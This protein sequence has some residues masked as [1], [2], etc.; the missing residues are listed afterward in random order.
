MKDM[1]GKSILISGGTSGIG[2]ETASELVLSGA[3]VVLMA[4]DH[5]RGAKAIRELLKIGAQAKKEGRVE[6]FGRAMFSAGDVRHKADCESAVA[7]TVKAFGGLDGLVC[8]AGIYREGEL[9]ALREEELDEVFDTNAKGTILL[10]QAALPVLKASKGAIVNVSSDA[11]V[12]GNYFAAAYCASKG[13]V[14]LFTRALALETAKDGVRVN[15]VAPGDIDTP[16]TADQLKNA[17]DPQRAAR[18]MAAVYPLGR[19][20]KPGEVAPA[21]AFLLSPAAA[22]VTGAIWSIDGG[23]TA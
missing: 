15:A 4:R 13:A 21:I 2:F 23:L 12:H 20:G 14:C 18:E 6:T 17:Q 10:C 7:F 9:E 5:I 11:G 1:A 16:L 22:F 3:N 19:I 8:S